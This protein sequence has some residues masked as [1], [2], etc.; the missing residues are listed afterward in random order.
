MAT[1][2]RVIPT[3]AGLAAIAAATDPESPEALEVSTVVVGDG[4]G[5]PVTPLQTMTSLVNQRASVPV[6]EKSRSDNKLTIKGVIDAVTGGFTIREIGIK[7]PDGILLFVGNYPDTYKPLPEDGVAGA[8]G[9]GAIVVISDTAAVTITLTGTTYATIDQV[10]E[11]VGNIRTDIRTPLRPYHLTVKSLTLAAPPGAPS[12]GDSYIVAVD[13]TG[14]WA[15]KVGQ[16]TQYI[17]A[18]V[19]WVFR[20]MPVGH[21]VSSEAT[22]LIHQRASDGKWLVFVPASASTS[23]L[24]LYDE[25]AL[26]G[27]RQRGW[28]N[29][30]NIAALAA[31][32]PALARNDLI[33]IH[34]VSVGELRNVSAEAVANL[35][36]SSR[37]G[38]HFFFSGT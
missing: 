13:A 8:L 19:G 30:F 34:D 23:R 15:G 5:N 2:Y 6:S 38:Y 35:L 11:I 1:S 20:E 36:I 9:V 27:G 7:D 18:G 29:P 3:L 31:V 4:N 10:N 37:I 21:L 25:P 14:A 22:G 26:G 16:M 12:P 28:G 17:S 33:A 32:S 24:Y